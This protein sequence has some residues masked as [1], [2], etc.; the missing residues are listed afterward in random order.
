MSEVEHGYDLHV[1]FQDLDH[2][3]E[4]INSDNVERAI[5]NFAL[6]NEM[7]YGSDYSQKSFVVFAHFESKRFQKIGA[8]HQHSSAG[9]NK[10]IRSTAN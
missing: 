10:L 9:S 6:V 1:Q 7:G 5:A 4:V 3:F 2:D 8:T